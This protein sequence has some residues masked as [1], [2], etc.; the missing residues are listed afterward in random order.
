MDE[1]KRSERIGFINRSMYD[2]SKLTGTLCWD[3]GQKFKI[4][5]IDRDGKNCVADVRRKTGEKYVAKNGVEYDAYED[6]G[7][8]RF[9]SE[10]GTGELVM[11]LGDLGPVKYPFQTFLDVDKSGKEVRKLRFKEFATAKKVN[12]FRTMFDQA[13]TVVSEKVNDE[14]PF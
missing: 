10:T 5:N 12:A 4:A 11:N 9:D 14:V 13:S 7:A 3:G 6:I 8:L 2:P 1:T